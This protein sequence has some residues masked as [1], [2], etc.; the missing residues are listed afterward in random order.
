MKINKNPTVSNSFKLHKKNDG[1][2]EK[3]YRVYGVYADDNTRTIV[4]YFVVINEYSF[5][6]ELIK[7]FVV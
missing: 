6:F 3:F 7:P 2:F 4:I 5:K 1:I